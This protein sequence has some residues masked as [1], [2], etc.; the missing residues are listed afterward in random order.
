MNL[1]KIRNQILQEVKPYVI[2][3]GWNENLFVNM[4]NN[5]NFTL[6]EMNVSFP[7]GY[8]TLIEMYLKEINSKMTVE[9]QK[10]NLIR[11]RI[12]E[13]IREIFILRLKN[14]DA[15]HVLMD[16]P[17]VDLGRKPELDMKILGLYGIFVENSIFFSRKKDIDV[18]FLGQLG[19]Y[20]SH[21]REYIEFL[22]ESN[23]S[24]YIS[25]FERD[26]QVDHAKYS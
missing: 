2:K 4:V 24:V 14:I 11:L 22:M 21:R 25:V 13:R 3:Y 1:K 18:S 23:L 26:N 5:S 16:N 15:T 8:T 20:R 9:S 17:L 19:E 10:I 6:E 12:H 7:K